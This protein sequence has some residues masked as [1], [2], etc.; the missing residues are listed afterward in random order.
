MVGTVHNCERG[1]GLSV[2]PDSP[3]VQKGISSLSELEN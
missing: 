3:E 2:G 1:Y